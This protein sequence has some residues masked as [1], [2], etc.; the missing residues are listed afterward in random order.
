[1]FRG[2]QQQ[3]SVIEF[4]Q[5]SINRGCCDMS[6]LKLLSVSPALNSKIFII[7]S[8]IVD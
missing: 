1:M 4:H 2:H 6:N 3:P 5:I 7:L 8:N